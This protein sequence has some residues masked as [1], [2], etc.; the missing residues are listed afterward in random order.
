MLGLSMFEVMRGE[1]ALALCELAF[2]AE[3]ERLRLRACLLLQ[4][5]CNT[6]SKKLNLEKLS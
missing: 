6:L 1:V 4:M 2:G 5:R 3:T